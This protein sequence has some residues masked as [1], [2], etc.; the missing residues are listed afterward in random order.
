VHGIN[1]LIHGGKRESKLKSIVVVSSGG[2]QDSIL[3]DMHNVANASPDSYISQ[4][5]V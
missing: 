1:V 3:F 4:C 5:M 2:S